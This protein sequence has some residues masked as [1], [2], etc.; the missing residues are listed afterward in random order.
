MRYANSWWCTG[1]G[2]PDKNESD[3][4]RDLIAKIVE[5][6]NDR[7][8]GYLPSSYEEVPKKLNYIVVEVSVKRFNRIGSEGMQ[9][10]SVEGRSAIYNKNDFDE[11]LD[12]IQRFLDKENAEELEKDRM[13]RFLWDMTKI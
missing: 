6:T 7:M 4:Q 5:I 12:D 13:I 10:E 11:Y 3:N 2:F 9:S 1:F 8:M